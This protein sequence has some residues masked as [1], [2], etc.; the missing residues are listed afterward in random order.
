MLKQIILLNIALVIFTKCLGQTEFPPI[1]KDSMSENYI[2]YYQQ[3]AKAEEAI[4]LKEYKKATQIYSNAFDEFAFNNP[5]DCYVAAQ[6]T[7]YQGDT[8]L[9]K[10]FLLKG[11]S[12]GIPILTIEN[13]PHLN[14]YLTLFDQQSIDSCKKVY[15]KRINFVARK[16]TISLSKRDNELVSG[17]KSIYDKSGYIL[18]EEYQPIWDSLLIELNDIILKYGFPAQKIIGTHS[19]ND[20]LFQVNPHSNYAYFILIHHCNAWKLLG[21]TLLLELRKGNIT[22]QMYGAI[23]EYS[24]GQNSANLPIQYFAL[25]PCQNKL[26]EQNLKLLNRVKIDE[27]RWSI[28]LCSLD[29]MERKFELNRKYYAWK[30]KK[31]INNMP[32][33]DFKCDLN[34]FQD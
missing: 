30:Q 16:R 2:E 13:N 24:N 6:L 20:N 27:D 32:Y 33:F 31:S 19:K 3:I 8:I 28:G 23:Y 9:T 12:F 29:I 1:V 15:A 34:F 25:R 5:I 26:C 14:P 7:A 11:I 17:K 4:V 22:P 21:N 18:K 10:T